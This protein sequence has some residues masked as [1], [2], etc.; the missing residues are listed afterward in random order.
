MRLQ[1]LLNI[2]FRVVEPLEQLRHLKSRL[3]VILKIEVAEVSFL[4]KLRLYC[5]LFNF[6]LSFYKLTK[7][8]LCELF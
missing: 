1:K 2:L 7:D 3:L 5:N 4:S 6:A 8:L